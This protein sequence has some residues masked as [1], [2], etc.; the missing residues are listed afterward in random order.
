MRILKIILQSFYLAGK[1]IIMT[2]R[3]NHARKK[4]VK[5]FEKELLQIGLDEN[6]ARELR[7]SYASTFGFR[8]LLNN[9]Q[10][11]AFE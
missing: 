8:T 3:I 9:S 11:K 1:L 6:T 4:G 7:K 2:P 10:V 5:A